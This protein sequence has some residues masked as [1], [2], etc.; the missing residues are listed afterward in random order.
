MK[1]NFILVIQNSGF[2][3]FV[4]NHLVAQMSAGWKTQLTTFSI[5]L[6]FNLYVHIHMYRL[7]GNTAFHI[8]TSVHGEN[9]GHF[10]LAII[11]LVIYFSQISPV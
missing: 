1:Q 6:Y 4:T 2:Q 10:K 11:H 3:H 7:L 9:S 8:L 5:N